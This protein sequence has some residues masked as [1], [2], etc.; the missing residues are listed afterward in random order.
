MAKTL[1]SRVTQK[2]DTEANWKKATGFAPMDGEL[3]VYQ[4]DSAGNNFARLKI[5]DGTTNVN[6]LNFVNDAPAVFISS[7]LLG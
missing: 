5:G 4:A 7:S 3:I 1:K 6:N 2:R